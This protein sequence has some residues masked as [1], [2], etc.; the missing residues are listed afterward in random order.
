MSDFVGDD[1]GQLTLVATVELNDPDRQA[2]GV[3]T[4]VSIGVDD[5]L[6]RN[7]QCEFRNAVS[8]IPPDRGVFPQTVG[9]RVRHDVRP[10]VSLRRRGWFLKLP[11][12][13]FL[14]ES[15]NR[16]QSENKNQHWN[17]DAHGGLP[18]KAAAILVSAAEVSMT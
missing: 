9:N 2:N 15:R 7:Y 16:N 4:R 12:L 14:S 8:G 5:L 11:G 3:R 1:V 18:S 17:R 13:L 10:D 6:I